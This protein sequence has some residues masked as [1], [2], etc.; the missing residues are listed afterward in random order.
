MSGDGLEKRIIERAKAEGARL[1]GIVRV[2][3]LKNAPSYATYDKDPF[4]PEYGGIEWQEQYKSVLVWGLPH[5]PSEPVLDWWSMKVKGFTPGNR[6]LA[7]QSKRL[8]VWM[9]EELG[10]EALSAPYQIEYGGAFL[11]DSAALAGLGVIGQNNLLV[12][13]Q[14]GPRLRLRALFMGAELEPTGPLTDFDPCAACDRPCHRVCPRGAFRSGRFARAL[15]KQEQDQRDV[16]FEV[17]DG[18]I[19][20]VEDAVTNVTAYCRA[21]EL[22]C[23]VSP[24]DEVAGEKVA[25]AAGARPAAARAVAPA[26]RSADERPAA[27]T[28][29]VLTDDQW[30]A[31]TGLLEGRSQALP[32]LVEAAATPRPFGGVGTALQLRELTATDDVARFDCGDVGLNDYLVRRAYVERATGKTHVAAR[33]AGVAACFGL[34]AATVSPSATIEREPGTAPL[35]V[36]AILLRRLAVDTPEQ[37]HGL[38]EA[39]LVEALSR[40]LQAADTMFARAVLAYAPTARARAFYERYGFETSPTDP[41]HLVVRMKDIRKSLAPPQE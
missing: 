41:K 26:A 3:D 36:P 28:R 18:A 22:A 30:T 21:C 38:G 19:M 10:M 17:M 27:Q 13:P 20:G 8:R 35:D 33:G 11:K 23:P 34:K 2:A 9:N 12:T 24:I 7:A 1:A 29:F 25:G 31:F 39:V 4:Y 15:C 6:E 16:D 32:P 37:G 14:F 5:P 40:C